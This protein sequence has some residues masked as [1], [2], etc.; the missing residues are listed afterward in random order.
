[1]KRLSLILSAA[2]SL[3]VPAVAGASGGTVAGAVRAVTHAV[4]EE[5]GTV[6]WYGTPQVRC[7]RT[8]PNHFGCSFL[9]ILNAEGAGPHGRVTVTYRRGHYY[10]GEPRFERSGE[11]VPLCGTAYTC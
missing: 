4:A 9:K 3:A 1:M 11:Y 8:T 5:G 10:V 7:R 2:V 6:Y